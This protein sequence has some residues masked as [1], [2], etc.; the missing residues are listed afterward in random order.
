MIIF[1]LDLGNK[2]T[3]LFSTKTIGNGDNKVEGKVLPSHFLYYDDLG[4]AETSVFG[5]KLNIRKYKTEF[6]DEEYG[7]GPDLHKVHNNENLLDTIGFEKRYSTH[8]FKLLANFALGELAKDFEEATDNILAVNVVTGVPSDDFNESSVKDLIKVLNGRHNITIDDV[9]YTVDVKEVQVIPQSIGTVYNEL[10]DNDGHIN[11]EKEYYLEEETTVV[12]IG[13][14]TILIDTLK[15]MNLASKTQYTTGIYTLYDMIIEKAKDKG[16]EYSSLTAYDLEVILREGND[17]KGYYFKPNKNVT[18]DISDIVKR[19]RARYTRDLINKIN[20]TIKSTS[21]TDTMLL[22]GGGANLVDRDEIVA[23]Y[24]FALFAE[25]SETANSK[26]FFKYGK[27][28]M[29]SDEEAAATV[30]E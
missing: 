18:L 3:K 11:P 26:G 30:E 20:K 10:L 15:N 4:N 16:N 23:R 1:G 12:D 6:D 24:K 27:A 9:S 7:W 17:D 28:V 29:N 19:V 2:Q 13:G 21:S 8:E 14:G 5:N 25:N 22:T